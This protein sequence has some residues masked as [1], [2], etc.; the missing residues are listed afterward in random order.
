[1]RVCALSIDLD[2]IHHYYAI[3][4]L[5]PPAP[6]AAHCVYDIALARYR[7]FA[8]AHRV[9]LTFF[10]VGADLQRVG[11]GARLAELSALGHELANHSFDHWYDLSRRPREQILSQIMRANEAIFE[12]TG[13]R[14]GGFR[15]PGY[16][17]N[18]TVYEAVAEAGLAYSSSVFPCPYYYVA[19]LGKL[20][21]LS[22]RGRGSESIATG[23]AVLLAP[24]KPY[25]IGKPYW[26]RGEG[27]L[28]LPIQV[29]PRLRLPVF[30]TSLMLLGPDLARRLARSLARQSFVNIE[31]HGVDLL[32]CHDRLSALAPHQFD[33]QFS[34]ERK[35]QTLS[36]VVE[37]LRSIG[38]GFVRLDEAASLAAR[39]Q[40]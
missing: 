36:A 6:G 29:T 18:D 24:R 3:H 4:G 35:W 33:L 9:P 37:E 11:N 12:H 23:P 38:F 28:E 13:Q 10:T 40:N 16:V 39:L 34:L 32:D 5:T 19:K 1:M 31:L 26:R 30:G 25:R 22:L 2:E 27:I 17:M 21:E 20:A 15:A 8:R 14:A 7:D